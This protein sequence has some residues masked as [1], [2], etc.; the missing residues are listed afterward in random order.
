MKTL[1]LIGSVMVALFLA[2]PNKVDAQKRKTANEASRGATVAQPGFYIKLSRCVACVPS[3]RLPDA[4]IAFHG[5]GFSAFYGSPKYDKSYANI[6]FLEKLPGVRGPGNLFVGPFQ[7]EGTAQSF[8]SEIPSILRKQI[9]EDQRENL[10]QA[11]AGF[12]RRLS[13][14]ETTGFFEVTVV[15]VLSAKITGSITSSPPEDFVIRPGI[16]VGRVLIGNSRSDVLAALG[17]PRN[18][19]ADTDSWYS[20]DGGLTVCYRSGAVYQIKVT[21]AK[22]HTA[23]GLTMAASGQ[24]FL[25]SFPTSTKLCC[26]FYGASGG[27]EWTSWDAVTVGIALQKVSSITGTGG[28]DNALIVHKVKEAVKQL[29]WAD[30][31]CKPCR[32]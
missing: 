4:M 29:E 14:E 17:K 10:R 31:E 16:G 21:S 30:A 1:F 8:V 13:P 3:R 22:F 32:R 23:T 28:F 20:K 9:A 11:R 7:T 25:R 5:R 26:A 12:A 2:A 18:A 6:E 24:L 27:E 15:R 19:E